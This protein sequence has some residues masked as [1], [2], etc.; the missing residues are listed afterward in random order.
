ML[1]VRQCQ[2]CRRRK[3]KCS[4]WTDEQPR[5]QGCIKANSECQF[6]N[7]ISISQ[8]HHSSQPPLVSPGGSAGGYRP[9]SPTLQSPSART[10]GPQSAGGPR[11]T[12]AFHPYAPPPQQQSPYGTS[13]QYMSGPSWMPSPQEESYAGT[14]FHHLLDP[15]I[16]PEMDSPGPGVSSG[17][18]AQRRL[19]SREGPSAA[20][21]YSYDAPGGASPLPSPLTIPTG[22]KGGMG[23]GGYALGSPSLGPS[24]SEDSGYGKLMYAPFQPNSGGMGPSLTPSSMHGPPSSQLH[25]P[26]SASH[27]PPPSPSSQST[28]SYHAPSPQSATQPPPPPPQSQ[29]Q[30]QGYPEQQRLSYSDQGRQYY[31]SDPRNQPYQQ[32]PPQQQEFLIPAQPRRPTIQDTTPVSSTSTIL[33]YSTPSTGLSSN[34]APHQHHSDYAR[35]APTKPESPSHATLSAD[36]QTLTP[37][38]LADHT[39]VQETIHEQHIDAAKNVLKVENGND[40]QVIEYL[41]TLPPVPSGGSRPGSQNSPTG[42]GHV[43]S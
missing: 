7:R 25:T 11:R 2:R 4:G 41:D 39:H 27:F 42:R 3:I 18:I 6:V 10:F 26:S 20:G 32:G 23:S 43:D 14:G 9:W 29:Y 21:S 38:T 22:Y 8:P 40:V 1:T 17:N 37:Q 12:Q 24:P 30:P 36:G 5:C 15:Q 35:S 13:P 33:S 34:S 16:R 31:M 19:V 28:Q